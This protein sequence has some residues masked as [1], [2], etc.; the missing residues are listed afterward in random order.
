MVKVNAENKG[1]V[2]YNN[3]LRQTSKTPVYTDTKQDIFKVLE[4]NKFRNETEP[5]V[6]GRQLNELKSKFVGVLEGY[7]QRE[8]MLMERCKYL[9]GE[10]MKSK[11]YELDN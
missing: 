4:D 7:K 8:R 5:A 3:F 6:M 1:L 10:L 11:E 2:D 9:E